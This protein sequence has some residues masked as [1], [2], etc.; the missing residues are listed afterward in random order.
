MIVAKK[1]KISLSI[2]AHNTTDVHRGGMTGLWMTLKQLEEKYPI[3]SQRPGNLIWDLTT[4]TIT[5]DWQGQDLTVI[6]WLLKQSFQ[7]SD[8]GLIHFI[9]LEHSLDLINQIHIHQAIHDTF[10]RHNRFYRKEREI[11]E[12]LQIKDK[13]IKLKYR[14]L[15]WYV[16]QTFAKDLC[17]E[18]GYL[19]DGYIQIVSWLYP[20]A[21]VRHAKLHQ[22]TKIEEKTEYALALLF[23][24]LVCQYFIL[25]YHSTKSDK[26]Q[27]IRYAIAIPDINNFEVAATRCWQLHRIDYQDYHVTNLGEAALKYFSHTQ[28]ISLSKE[29]NYCQ[30]LLYE[31]LK[32]RSQQRTIND[33][34]DFIITPQAIKDYQFVYRNFQKN[35]I[36]LGKKS[37]VV[38]VNLIR[39]IIAENLAHNLSWWS[40]FWEIIY[41][42]DFFG[43][44]AK[45]L[46]F[47]RQGLVSMLEQDTEL[48]IYRDFIH[49]FH[50]ALRK[51]YAKTYDPKKTKKENQLKI[52]KKYESIRSE[53]SRCYDQQSLEDFLSDLLSR[54]GWNGKLRETWQPILPLIFQDIPW[55]KTRNLALIA[56]ASYQPQK[57]R[58][59]LKDVPIKF[60]IVLISINH[61]AGIFFL[62]RR[63]IEDVCSE[64]KEI[65]PESES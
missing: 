6:D 45:Q 48:D 65:F 16:H 9:G 24:P 44:L 32:K 3:P 43:D 21:T 60:W 35:I 39:A 33:F 13:S 54:A 12:I 41:E 53:L 4:T 11:S 23:L 62:D 31:K 64:I 56:L 7:I 30:V 2:K 28:N 19:I 26:K 57:R 40:D 27:P 61:Q 42:R 37:F 10:L 36:F 63:L 52:D 50:E 14:G 1:P 5:L 51:I 38:N 58:L 34:Q 20:G 25:H 22:K 18:S 59:L 55:Q 8:K 15:N 49:A 29:R 17:D 46:T 47:N